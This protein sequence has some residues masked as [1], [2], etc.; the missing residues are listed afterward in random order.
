MPATLWRFSGL[1]ACAHDYREHGLGVC[2]FDAYARDGE[3]EPGCPCPAG[4]V[5]A[6]APRRWSPPE[7]TPLHDDRPPSR[8]RRTA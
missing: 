2:G 6:H 7:L 3:L 5:L 4:W 1:C 8:S